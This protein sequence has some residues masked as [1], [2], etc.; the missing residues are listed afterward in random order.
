MTL[1]ELIQCKE[2]LLRRLLPISMQ[3]LKIVRQNN[4]SVLLHH[5]A[6]KQRLMNE[7][8]AIEQQLAPFQAIP[9]EERKWNNETERLETNAAIE[10]CATLLEEIIQNDSI[11]MDELTVQ[12]T[13]T[14]NQLRR[15]RQGSQ[16]LSAYT[17]FR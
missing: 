4:L 1:S 5:L 9:P 16:V 6:T 7:F 12:K 11:S 17:K 8:E 15:V 10:R 3:Q 2:E 14:E 13:E